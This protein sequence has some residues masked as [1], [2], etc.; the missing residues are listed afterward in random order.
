MALDMQEELVNLREEVKR[1]RDTNELSTK[2][3][4]KSNTL[5]V[6]LSDDETNIN[7]CSRCWDKDK[8]LIQVYIHETGDF[9]CPEC[10]TKALFSKEMEEEYF[11]RQREESERESMNGNP[12][13][14]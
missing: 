4:R 7:Y 1:L 6:T 14:W 9:V 8:N 2:I 11:R 10:K 3:V 12:F 5:I 13:G